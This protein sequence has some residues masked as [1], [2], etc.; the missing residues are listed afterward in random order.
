MYSGSTNSKKGLPLVEENR[1]PPPA[2]HHREGD[3]PNDGSW[4]QRRTSVLDWLVG[5]L[6][7]Q[8][9]DDGVERITTQVVLDILEVPQSRRRAGT[10][11]RLAKLMTELDGR[12]YEYAALR[13]GATWS[14]CA[15]SRGADFAERRQ[16]RCGA[17]L[18][19]WRADF[20][21]YTL[22]ACWPLRVLLTVARSRHPHPTS[23]TP[24]N[25]P[26][27]PPCVRETRGTW[28]SGSSRPPEARFRASALQY[29][30]RPRSACSTSPHGV[31]HRG[32][33]GRTVKELPF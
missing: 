19:A 8:V 31:L 32:R 4:P 22:G 24:I 30:C 11:R 28:A 7:G 9:G 26:N 21:R 1:Q 13:V 16:S 3:G 5:R 10:N 23:R 18:R 27:I 33:P 12:R 2:P 20:G 29:F 17:I 25:I 6:R 14:R 15:G